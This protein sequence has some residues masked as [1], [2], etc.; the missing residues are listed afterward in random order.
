MRAFALSLLLGLAACGAPSP[1]AACLDSCSG[2]CEADGTCNPAPS[3]ASCGGPGSQCVQCGAGLQCIQG[4]CRTE[5]IEPQDGGPTGAD[6]GCSCARPNSVAVCTSDG[7]CAIDRCLDGF[8][9]TDGLASNGCEKACQPRA[10]SAS[11][12][13]DLDVSVVT[14]SGQV[15]VDGRTPSAGTPRGTLHFE[16]FDGTTVKVDL[17]A[18]GAAT[19]RTALFA[20]AYRVRFTKAGDCV[21]GALPCTDTVLHERTMLSASGALDFDLRPSTITKVDLVRVTGSVSVNGTPLPALGATRGTV[22]FEALATAGG[23]GAMATIAPTGAPTYEAQLVKGQRYRVWVDGTT[24]CSPTSPLPCG[25]GVVL[26]EL[27]AVAGVLDLDA[28]VITL[29]GQLTMNGATVPGAVAASLLFEDPA[30]L[31]SEVAVALPSSGPRTYT[32]RLFPG[33][34]DVTLRRAVCTKSDALPCGDYQL[35]QAVPLAASGALDLDA[36]VVTVSGVVTANGQALPPA[37][38]ALRGSLG[39]KS[40][41][42]FLLFT[43]EPA[44]PASFGGPVYAGTYDVGVLGNDCPNGGLPCFDRTVRTRVPL[45]A[46]GALDVDVPAVTIQAGLTVNQATMAQASSGR[47]TLRFT[48]TEGGSVDAPVPPTGAANV[49]VTLAPGVYSVS[50]ARSTDCELDVP[51]AM[52]TVDPAMV[53]TASGSRTFDLPVVRLAGAV[54]VDGAAI[55]PHPD[56]RG[57]LLFSSDAGDMVRVP[58][59]GGAALATYRAMLFAGTWKVGIEGAMD[60]AG[61]TGNTVPCAASEL[62]PARA[63]TTSGALDVDV[64]LVQ[65][66]GQVTVNRQPMPPGIAARGALRFGRLEGRSASQ[67]SLGATG[68]ATYSVRLVRG[69]YSIAIGNDQACDQGPLPCQRALLEGCFL[70]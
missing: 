37:K 12:A 9:N 43:L 40:A 14:L 36:P 22:R 48:S 6:A 51:C 67:S 18:T 16:R 8:S 17:P 58:I 47:G 56:A 46:N 61:L 63:L 21:D 27:T 30:K 1:A 38:S 62:L 50:Y 49:T 55:P 31:R 5:P 13:L 33:V 52:R 34:T 23:A 26:P 32:T 2:C 28:K 24:A 44:G 53:V 45:V 57:A 19:Y 20:G 64:P 29:S 3:A 41:A 60:C 70:P 65:L 54:T 11:G 42:S 39:F 35:K 7:G 25:R 69:A 66:A 10:F 59:S 68:P 4:A 15:T